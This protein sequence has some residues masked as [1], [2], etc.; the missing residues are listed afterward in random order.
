MSMRYTYDSENLVYEVLDNEVVLV[1]LESGFYYILEGT[2]S[3]IWQAVTSGADIAGTVK[4]LLASYS[5]DAAQVQEAVTTF[6]DDLLQEGLL[7]PSSAEVN[8]QPAAPAQPAM[9]MVK[10][11]PFQN[12]SMLKYTD[13]EYLIQMD[14][15]WEY[16]EAGWPKRRTYSPDASPNTSHDTS[17]NA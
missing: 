15:I 5:G 2:A 8:G 12:P 17:P 3:E 4:E 16:D 7:M 1:N 13:M 11:R 14:P 9:G 6:V 10:K